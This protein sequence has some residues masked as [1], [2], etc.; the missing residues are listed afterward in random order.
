[1]NPKAPE[2][3]VILPIYNVEE[4][5]ARALDSLSAQ[6]FQDFEAICVDDGSPDGCQKL[7]Q[8]Y[9]AKD[10]RIKIL[11]QSNRGVSDARNAGLAQA[12]GQYVYFMDPDDYIHPQL[13]EIAHYFASK[14]RAKIV[15]FGCYYTGKYVED[16]HVY[17]DLHELGFVI[18][19]NPLK[20][21][22]NCRT[23][24]FNSAVW[25]KMYRRDFLADAR[26]LP[27]THYSEDT[28][29]NLG[30]VAHNPLTVLINERLYFYFENRNSVVQRPVSAKQIAD[31]H[32]IVLKILELF[33]N[34]Y[35]RQVW[36]Y[37]FSD[38][39]RMLRK[40]RA[41]SPSTRAQ[42]ESEF[43]KIVSDLDRAGWLRVP[44]LSIGKLAWLVK[45]KILSHSAC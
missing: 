18:T 39:R 19:E 35:N 29:F 43:A 45:M 16:F 21:F 17:G 22:C 20:Y 40:I 2:I 37:L 9:A 5:L 10:A 8:Q 38:L 14:H 4:F 7:L 13:L 31:F 27:D 30:L 23:P 42:L 41:D 11:T 26:F 28:L 25:S 12:R 1:M 32:K 3:S 15:S 24:N 44:A 36:K 6:T 34:K 33:D